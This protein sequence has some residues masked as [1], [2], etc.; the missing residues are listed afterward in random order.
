MNEQPDTT[1]PS[2]T[3]Q[4]PGRTRIGAAA[5]AAV[6][7][8]GGFVGGYVVN[9]ATGSAA[10]STSAQAGQ[11]GPGGSGGGPGGSGSMTSGTIT[12]VDGDTVTL[13]TTDGSTVTVTTDSDTTVTTSTEGTVS[14]LAAG[15]TVQVQGEESDGSVT[16]TSISEGTG[17]MGGGTPPGQGSSS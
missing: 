5:A 13:E 1:T 3:P 4:H 9:G 8:L 6:L 16:A 11:G 17:A 15:D 2:G 10:A 14:D 12:A 7:L